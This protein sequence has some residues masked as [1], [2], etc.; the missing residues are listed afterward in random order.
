M[1]YA[2]QVFHP[3]IDFRGNPNAFFEPS[4]ATMCHSIDTSAQSLHLI[5]VAPFEKTISLQA[6]ITAI[7]S[8]KDSTQRPA[9]S[10]IKAS[11]YSRKKTSR[12]PNAR[13]WSVLSVRNDQRCSRS[14]SRTLSTSSDIAARYTKSCV[15]QGRQGRRIDR[16]VLVA[17][18][19]FA[20]SSER[21]L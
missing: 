9:Q 19:S 12:D 18:K 10:I 8:R 13:T 17:R 4:V 16:P 1:L 2:C 11:L 15:Y 3:L 21:K 7:D 20:Q 14:M 6:G 5:S